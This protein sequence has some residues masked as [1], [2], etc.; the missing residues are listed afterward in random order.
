MA[1]LGLAIDEFACNRVV[2]LNELVDPKAKLWD[3]GKCGAD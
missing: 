3:D 1:R 2:R